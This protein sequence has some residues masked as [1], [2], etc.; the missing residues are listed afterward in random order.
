MH[1][2]VMAH[3][4]CLLLGSVNIRLATM[5]GGGQAKQGPEVI[6]HIKLD[7]IYKNMDG[8]LSKENNN[9]YWAGVWANSL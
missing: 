9:I 7:Q 5:V 3:A 1:E 8:F 6:P 4:V 2:I